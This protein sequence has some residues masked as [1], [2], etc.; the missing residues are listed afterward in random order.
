VFSDLAAS[1]LDSY[2]DSYRFEIFYEII[3]VMTSWFPAQATPEDNAAMSQGW[4]KKSST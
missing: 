1:N 2:L 4:K 3:F